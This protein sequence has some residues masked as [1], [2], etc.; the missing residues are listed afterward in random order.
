MSYLGTV[1]DNED[2]KKLGRLKIRISP[3]MDYE[4]EDLPWACPTLG[5]HG[6][7]SE[8]GGLN[9]PEVGAQV[10]VYFPSHD[11]TAPYYTGAELNEVNR[12]TFFD[13]D[14][15]NTYGYKDSTGNFIK[16]NKAKDTIQLQHTSTSTMKVSPDGSMQ[17]ALSNGAY[18]TF[19]NSNAF[20]LSIGAV[21]VSGTPDG[22]LQMKANMSIEL[23]APNITLKAK[24]IQHEGYMAANTGASGSFWAYNS[25]IEVTD[26]LITYIG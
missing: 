7:T 18:F 3:Y 21:S 14:Y 24:T 22:T 16:I 10:R 2:P 6:N 15:P 20:D 12:T 25:Y 4:P 1:E 23:D 11:L 8:A 19:S 13:D 9:V 26:G 5:T 17:I